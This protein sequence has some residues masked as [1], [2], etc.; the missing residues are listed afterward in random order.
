MPL[1]NMKMENQ[2]QKT[3]TKTDNA[4]ISGSKITKDMNLADIVFKY[5]EAAEVLLDY[6]LHCVGCIASSFDTIEMGA[7][8]HGMSDEEIDEM[9][10]RI[11]EVI[12]HKE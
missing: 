7:K 8:A 2:I 4:K 9:T 6:G 11:N 12:E 1:E 10:V 3:K 5:P